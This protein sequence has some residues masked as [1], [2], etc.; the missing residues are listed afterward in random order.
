MAVGYVS[1]NRCFA[2]VEAAEHATHVIN[3]HDIGIEIIEDGAIVG[4]DTLRFVI[5]KT[6]NV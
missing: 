3:G 6:P 5:V 4:I 2:Q 1:G